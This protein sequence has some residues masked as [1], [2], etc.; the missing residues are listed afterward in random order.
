MSAVQPYACTERCLSSPK[1]REAPNVKAET[2]ASCD[3]FVALPQR[4]NGARLIENV[5]ETLARCVERIRR[6]FRKASR[7]V[8]DCG[9]M[10]RLNWASGK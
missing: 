10:A 7:R 5:G 2:G 4:L 1:L 8:G 9:N 6:R 3:K